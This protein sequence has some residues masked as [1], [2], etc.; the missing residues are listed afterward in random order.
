MGKMKGLKITGFDFA[1]GRKTILDI[2]GQNDTGA[3]T[4]FGATKKHFGINQGFDAY[5]VTFDIFG[6]GFK[7]QF[8][9]LV[10]T[11]GTVKKV[12]VQI[13][14][15][16]ALLVQGLSVP[17]LEAIDSY[18]KDE[19]FKAFARLLTGDDTIFGSTQDDDLWGGKGNDILWGRG[20]NDIVNGF[21]GNDVNDGGPGN[22]Y[23]IDTRGANTFQ[24]STPFKTGEENRDYNFDTIKKLKPVDRIYLTYDY[25]G[26]AGMKV[27]K[28]EL[29]FTEQAQD[30]NDYFLFHNRTFYY[31][32]D[33][34]GPAERTP[35]FQTEN[36][37]KL[38]H[39][40]I[41]IGYAGYEGP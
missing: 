23:L 17:A 24:F 7:Y 39:K 31:D 6:K 32:P 41:A 21:K 22:D 14:R 10:P 35:I 18:L 11:S 15:E 2:G 3:A 30:K 5:D 28:G 19:P 1:L 20:G 38:T 4:F 8:G 27:K 36:D 37:A 33:G 34:N 40:M 12:L 29:A 25:F 16:D 13:D 26:A 9:S